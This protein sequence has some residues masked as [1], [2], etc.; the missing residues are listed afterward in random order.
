MAKKRNTIAIQYECNNWDYGRI[1]G[2][3][4]VIDFTAQGHS[5]ADDALGIGTLYKYVN[6]LFFSFEFSIIFMN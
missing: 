3:A 6:K 2:S 5:F 4:A 1:A